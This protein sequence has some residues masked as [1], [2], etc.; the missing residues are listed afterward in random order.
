MES[1]T[2]H[3][4]LSQLLSQEPLNESQSNEIFCALLKGELDDPQIGG[5]LSLIQTMPPS[6][7]TLT[8]AARAMRAHVESVNYELDLGTSL[9]DTCGTGGA[10]KTFNV[11]TAA[12]IIAASVET[13]ADSDVSRIVVAKHG[14]RSRTG[15]GS[16]EVL[17][18][19]G[20]NVD[21]STQIQAQCLKK[22][23]VCFCFAIH[24]HPAM[25]HA[26]GPRRSLGFPTIF[27]A[28]GPLTNPAG[29]DRQLIG[30]YDNAL[31]EPMAQTLANLGVQR[32]MVVHAQDGLDELTTT[33]PTR[34]LHVEGTSLREEIID[35]IKFGLERATLQDLQAT[36][37]EHSAQIIREIVDGIPSPFADMAM[38]TTA[39][40]LIVAGVCTDFETGIQLTRETV[41][42][43]KAKTTLDRLI[44]VSQG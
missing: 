12:A 7:S 16:A 34:I 17:I 6:A 25:K 39:G 3:Q 30:V 38:L 18:A 5:L 2:I 29:A 36:S 33:A 40:A 44:E 13:P 37:L 11:S 27:N 35:P 32:A 31:V 26:M 21:A 8:G 10:P 4:S 9:I 42:T 28:L 24:H 1:S 41:A 15:R 19:L 43:G 22:V 23:G 14:N 20:V